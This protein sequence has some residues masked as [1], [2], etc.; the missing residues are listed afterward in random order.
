MAASKLAPQ[1]RKQIVEELH[2]LRLLGALPNDMAAHLAKNGQ[3]LTNRQ[4]QGLLAAADKMLSQATIEI[5]DEHRKKLVQFHFATRRMILARSL[6]QG[7]LRT[8]LSA[9]RD[10]CELLNLMPKKEQAAPAAPLVLNIIEVVVN[11]SEPT[12]VALLPNPEPAA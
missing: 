4:L 7:D 5:E 11:K 8:A 2:S 3:S 10:E 1:E 6:S 9:L 12:P